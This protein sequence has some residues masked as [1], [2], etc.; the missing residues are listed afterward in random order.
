MLAGTFV[1]VFAGTQLAGIHKLGD[2][3]SPGL[4]DRT[5]VARIV[6]ADREEADRIR[7][8]SSLRN[9][10]MKHTKPKRF[11]NNLIVIG[12]GSAGLIA[13]LIAA[14]V[15]AKVTLI[16]RARMGGDCLNTGCVPSKTLI[17]SAKIAHYLQ[18]CAP[19][20][21]ARRDRHG[22][23]RRCDAARSRYDRN[24]RA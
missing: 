11:D 15:R 22:R 17:R 23:L 19:L 16:E 14:T 8:T 9:C 20:W 1:F 21:S 3:L 13:S 4:I 7:R 24:D 5:D 18:G 10:T 12:A 2:V 6:S